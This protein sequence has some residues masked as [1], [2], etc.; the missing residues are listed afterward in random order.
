M[1][2]ILAVQTVLSII[3]DMFLISGLSFSAKLG[4]NGI[5]IANIITSV[6]SITLVL[7][8][9]NKEGIVLFQKRELDFSW[10]KDYG[11]IGLWSGLESF[12]RN[13]AF[14]LMV[15]R[16]VNVIAEQGNYWVANNF[17]WTWLLLPATALYDVIKKETAADKNNIRTKTLGYLVLTT[18]FSLIWFA[19]I[20]LWN[21]FLQFVMNA[22]DYG[23]IIYIVLV[24]SAFYVVYMYNC[25]F[26]GTIYGRG[27]TF[28]MF[29]QSIIINGIYYVTMFILWRTGYF[30]PS[31]MSISLMF[32]IGMALD[33]IPTIGCY[34]YLLRKEKVQIQ[35]KQ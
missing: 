1:Y 14:M 11:R 9:L 8:M 20:P 13:I 27:K 25:V 35:W 33:L 24:Q 23:T 17:I 16:L 5:A 22:Q 6:V 31:L 12:I 29:V 18:V 30:Q 15:S 34:L 28:Y 19:S 32:G 26:D 4:V 21:P 10:L 7:L 3:F 2:I